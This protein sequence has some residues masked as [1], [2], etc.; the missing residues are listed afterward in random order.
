MKFGDSYPA[1]GKTSERSIATSDLIHFCGN[2]VWRAVEAL[3]QAKDFQSN[4]AWI[5]DRL[6]ISVEAAK[7]ALEGLERIGMITRTETGYVNNSEYIFANCEKLDRS[8]MF[9]IHNKIK[10]QIDA[11]ITSRDSYAN[12][13]LLSNKEH[14]SRFFKKFEAIVEELNKSSSE[15]ANCNEVFSFELS[16]ARITREKV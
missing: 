9:S 12:T 6:N 8:D 7:D 13:I 3:V 5:A 2:W 4:P 15:D 11:K 1:G 14:V 16:L 10:D